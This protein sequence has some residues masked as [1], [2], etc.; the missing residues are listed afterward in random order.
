[1]IIVWR[2]WGFLSLFIIGAVTVVT[3]RGTLWVTETLQFPAWAKALD[4]AISLVMTVVVNWIAGRYLNRAS[5]S[6]FVPDDKTS[7]SSGDG[8]VRHDLF[9]IKMEHWSVLLFVIAAWLT[10]VAFLAR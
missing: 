5:K 2:G 4:I 3:L 9:F 6:R 1:M 8:A 7:R 10:T